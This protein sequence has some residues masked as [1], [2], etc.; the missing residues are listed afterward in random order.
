MA[1]SP[2]PWN[3]PLVGP[4][5]RGVRDVR[6]ACMCWKNILDVGQKIDDRESF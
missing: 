6:K 3:V 2:I 5:L 1:N 4:R